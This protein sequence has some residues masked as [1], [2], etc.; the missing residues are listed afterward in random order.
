MTERPSE[1]LKSLASF[2]EPPNYLKLL[3]NHVYP[4][5]DHLPPNQLDS[6]VAVLTT[7]SNEYNGVGLIRYESRSESI[8]KGLKVLMAHIES[9]WHDGHETQVR[10]HP[11]LLLVMFNFP[12]LQGEMMGEIV[13][14]IAKWIEDLWTAGVEEGVE[15]RLVHKSLQFCRSSLKKL[16]STRSR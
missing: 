16:G 14:E 10:C 7:A 4:F 12:A 6:L 5:L 3:E 2:H 9:D 1:L 15:H 8:T 13:G 11:Y